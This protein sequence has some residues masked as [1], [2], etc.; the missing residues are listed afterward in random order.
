MGNCWTFYVGYPV[1][2]ISSI[3]VNITLYIINRI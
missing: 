3:F 2:D 1:L